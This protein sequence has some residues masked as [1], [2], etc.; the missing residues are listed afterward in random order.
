MQKLAEICIRRPIFASMIVLSLVVVGA[1]S[2]GQ[3]GVDRF[4]PV[5][6]PTV[7]VRASLPGA[8][9]EEM[10]SEVAIPLEEAVNTV[11]G[12]T[13]LR[14]I[15]GQGTAIVVATFA[16]DRD[17]DVATQDVRDRVAAALPNLP[18][19][20]DPPLVRKFD[21][22]SSSVITVALS[23]DRSIRELT[24]IADK[25]VRPMLERVSGVG[26]V[27][28]DGGLERAIDVR[29]DVD[30]LAAYRIPITAV[31]TALQRQNAE[32]PGG[33]V[34]AGRREI[35]L[36]TLGRFDD[37]RAFQNLVVAD[38]NGS[39]VRLRDIGT[40]EDG[41][42]EQRTVSRLDGVPTVSVEVRRQAGAN[43][44][45]VINGVKQTLERV[46]AVLP[47][48]VSLLVIQD[49]SVYIENALHEINVHLVLGSILASLVVLAFMRNAR[50]TLIAAVA[51]PASLVAT[52]AMMRALGFTLNSVTMLAL[53]LMV[54]IVIDD[55][56]VVLENIFRFVEE[57]KMNT[58]E[59][60]RAATAD[61]GLAVLA[62]TFSLV[63]IFL[64]V[65]FMSSIS[66][67]FLYQFGITASAAILVS[68]L[69]SFTLT[70][71]MSAR[72]LRP[73]AGAGERGEEPG[74]RRGFY[75]HIDERYARLL[76]WSM[77]HRK[78]MALLAIGVALSSFAIF[79]FVRQE[80]IPGN[81]D[82]AE[83]EVN[84]NAP[85][86][87]SVSAMD[88]AMRAV[89]AEARQV[90]G[91]TSILASGGGG[92]VGGVNQ[93]ELFVRLKPHEERVFGFGRLW[94]ETKNLTPWRAFYGNY[95]Q[96]DVMQELR[97]R[98]RKFPHLR[99]SVRNITSF[100]I[101]GGRT[102]IVIALR[103]PD[104]VTLVRSI[105]KLRD[106][107]RSGQ[108][109]GVVDGD[110]GLQLD[111][112]ELRIHVDRDRAADLGVDTTDV[113]T[114]LRIMV[115]GDDRVSRYLDPQTNEDYDVQLRLDKQYRGD[116][117]TISRLYVSSQ[118]GGLVRLDNVVRIE[119]G[120]A[121][122]RIE[123]LDRQ[124]TVRFFAGVGPGYALGDRLVALRKA[125]DDMNLPPAYSVTV[126]GRGRE[127]ER[128]FAEF[129]LAFLLSIVFMYMILASQFESLID[130]LTILISLPLSVPFALFS[131]WVTSDTLNLYSALGVLVLFGIV[132]KNSILQIDH[133]NNLRREHGLARDQAVMQGNRDRLRPILM[134]TF[135][136]VAGMLPLAL[137][138][139]PGAEERRSIAIVVIGGQTLSLLLTLLATPVFYTLFEDAASSPRWK[140]LVGRV[141][142]PV[143]A[144]TGALKQRW[145]ER[146]ARRTALR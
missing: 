123:R 126:L 58:F 128:T 61:I 146:I 86:G 77:D 91:V 99:S 87:T 9:P 89:E 11:Q 135:A 60:A 134:T 103:G 33:N 107:T 1:V 72:L 54:G 23:A 22:D 73:H 84:V 143:D 136:L 31:R 132:K 71:M 75:H 24:E 141:R 46:K 140:A 101:G 96:R 42:K 130:P 117:D 27:T 95:S 70:P 80:F 124:R 120:Q 94:H 25:A 52:F 97:G 2:Y 92:F 118:A 113:A 109:P 104:V 7:M 142:P 65:S 106:L 49:Q 110:V 79:P 64:P 131:L 102:D 127:M 82:E 13:E 44:I 78:R 74:S 40:V 69:V 63:V 111:K 39:P 68:L 133:M 6:L 32:I 34:D 93:G 144:L 53:V 114:S 116:P 30:R 14:T 4:P 85:E 51:I 112:P 12:I 115:G 139:G 45:A 28:I 62:T 41:T 21:N 10:E 26:D 100:N 88:E 37:A 15:A 43:T 59:A 108:I 3:L 138:T 36:R 48:D 67:R 57:K 76:R 83:F 145:Q 35:A 17:I 66:G 105:E 47:T 19:D 56:I 129:A 16:L 20:I 137:G 90:E 121:P 98:L 122:S 8:A 55:A 18:R 50:A 5:D 125:L 81:V 29:I 119:E 38:V